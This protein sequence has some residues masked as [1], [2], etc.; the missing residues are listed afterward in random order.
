MQ[1]RDELLY[2]VGGHA[3]QTEEETARAGIVLRKKVASE[4]DSNL[5]EKV[6]QSCRGRPKVD[7]GDRLHQMFSSYQIV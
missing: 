5:I 1:F 3:P 7:L 6:I 4:V 2:L